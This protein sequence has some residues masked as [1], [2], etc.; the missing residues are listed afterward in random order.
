MRYKCRWCTDNFEFITQSQ[1]ADHLQVIHKIAFKSRDLSL[2]IKESVLPNASDEVH[3]I[4]DI[5]RQHVAANS[6]AMGLYLDEKLQKLKIDL[7]QAKSR[8]SS[9]C[10]HSTPFDAEDGSQC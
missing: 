2:Y 6:R 8:Y 1:L 7:I 5:V 3:R 4:D 9:G 10:R